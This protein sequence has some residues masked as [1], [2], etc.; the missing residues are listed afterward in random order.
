MSQNGF[1]SQQVVSSLEQGLARD[2][3]RLTRARHV[4]LTAMVELGHPFSTGELEQAVAR[5]DGS[6]GR[7][8]VYR[9][10]AL[11]ESR[12]LVEKL[13]R[14]G[15][16]HYTLCLKAEHHH[17]VTCV[18]C[19]RTREFALKD[20][21]DLLSTVDGLA[22]GLGYLPRSHVLEVYGVCPVCQK[23]AGPNA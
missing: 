21:I 2:G 3:F 19:G 9:T 8:S 20:N 12:G 10:L 1:E 4:V 22:R 5:V 6:V 23:L 7:A 15:Q 11:M 13:H 14:S 17:H 18:Q 16:E